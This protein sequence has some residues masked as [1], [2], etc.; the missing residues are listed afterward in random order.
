MKKMKTAN[1]NW[2]L[3]SYPTGPASILP[4]LS[5]VVLQLAPHL[6]RSGHIRSTNHMPCP[7]HNGAA[8]GKVKRCFISN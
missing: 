8:P 7:S 2:A 4:M 6:A 1:S 5:G 3:G